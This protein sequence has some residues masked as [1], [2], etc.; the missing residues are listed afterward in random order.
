M[1]LMLTILCF[2]LRPPNSKNSEL[3][4]QQPHPEI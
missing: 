1:R 2:E 4:Y 3:K